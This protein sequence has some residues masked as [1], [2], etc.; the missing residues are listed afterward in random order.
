MAAELAGA[1]WQMLVANPA[2]V[3]V[4]SIVLAVLLSQWKPDWA[5]SFFN[6]SAAGVILVVGAASTIYIVGEQ[7]AD[8]GQ[9]LLVSRAASAVL[10]GVVVVLIKKGVDIWANGG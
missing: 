5:P 6:L 4:L 3:F 9:A 8:G 10:I 1:G 2:T 7:G